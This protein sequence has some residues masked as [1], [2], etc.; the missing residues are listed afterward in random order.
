MPFATFFD[1][2]TLNYQEH[3]CLFHRFCFKNNNIS[4]IP[5]PFSLFLIQK[6]QNIKNIID[7]C[8]VFDPETLKY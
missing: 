2:E 4:R 6:Q 7:F 5:L 1:P 8:I 3:H